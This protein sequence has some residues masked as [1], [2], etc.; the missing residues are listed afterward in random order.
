M[1]IDLN[2]IANLIIHV[3]DYCCIVLAI[4]L[5]KKAHLNEKSGTL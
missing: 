4:N 2:S 1:S 3:F 5:L